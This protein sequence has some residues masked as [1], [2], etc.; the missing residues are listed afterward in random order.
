MLDL[1]SPGTFKAL[2]KFPKGYY[3]RRG[4]E[5]LAVVCEGA[6]AEKVKKFKLRGRKFLKKGN[7]YIAEF[8][9][10]DLVNITP[11]EEVTFTVTAMFEH[12]SHKCN[13]SE[14]VAFEGSDEV[15]VIGE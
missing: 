7:T 8:D 4:W 5:T 13:K 10:E 15:V 12:T 3:N 1:G 6:S 9:K 11:G 14:R 2:I